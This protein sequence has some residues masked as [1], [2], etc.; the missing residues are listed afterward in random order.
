MSLSPGARLG[1]YRVISL[2]GAGGMGE[3]YK[4][5]DTRL[6]RD[7]ALKTLPT[8]A[9]TDPERLARFEREARAAAALSHPNIC[10]I[11]DVGVHDGAPFIVS[12]LLDGETLRQ[13]LD[14]GPLP[15]RRAVA[16]ATDIARGLAAAHE[17]GIVHRDLKPENLFVMA[18]GRVKIL[19][20]GVAALM[21][22]TLSSEDVTELA[23]RLTGVGSAVGT[24]GYMSPEQI[25]G[26][27]TDGRSDIFSFGPVLFE[28]LAGRQPFR[29]D[30]AADTTSAILRE[31]FPPLTD[32]RVPPVLDRIIRRCLEKSPK[33]RYRSAERSRVHARSHFGHDDGFGGF[34]RRRTGPST[35]ACCA[36]RNLR[37]QHGVVGIALSTDTTLSGSEPISFYAVCHKS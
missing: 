25:S 1:P 31:H 27:P 16:H 14:G 19:D 28:V 2:I 18:D 8:G 21:Q 36:R 26:L 10:A 17:K 35:M 32:A 3:V 7:V 15:A 4:A 11:F 13:A 20:F 9:S 34:S 23:D 12:E 24:V 30:T 37:R 5:H 33:L 29:G 6:Q 22:S